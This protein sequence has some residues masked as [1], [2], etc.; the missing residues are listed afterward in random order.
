M[1]KRRFYR[2]EH[3]NRD[4]PSESS[5]SSD[6]EVEAEATDETEVEEEEEEENVAADVREKGEATSSSGYESEDSSANEVNLDS[7]GL[8]TSD[9]DVAAQAGGQDII[10]SFTSA[11]GNNVFPKAELTPEK[12]EVQFDAMDCV[13]KC[14]S[15]FKC[16]LCPRIVCLSEETLKAHLNSKRH[17]RSEKLRREGRLKLMLND[18]GQIEGETAPEVHPTTA[19]SGQK[20]DKPKKKGKG[21]WKQRKRSRQEIRPEKAR[22][23]TEKQG[24]RRKDDS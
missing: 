21:R 20:S 3:G 11:E 10:G 24:K 8:P 14:K 9:D 6:S 16:K 4:D 5:S 17:A 19:V 23:S 13:L 1:I 22:Q 12:D 18:D 2:F 7:S 15:V